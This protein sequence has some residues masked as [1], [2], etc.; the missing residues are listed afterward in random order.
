MVRERVTV[1]ETE[2]VDDEV[3]VTRPTPVSQTAR[4]IYYVMGVVNVLLL[5]RLIFQVFGA[6]TRSPFVSFIYGL[7]APLLAP[8]RGIFNVAAAGE[9]VID[10]AILVAMI[11]YALLAKGL[12]ELLYLLTR[13][14]VTSV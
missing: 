6:N 8:F 7:T 5:L 3:V 1:H 9:T 4:I 11:I 2:E 10:P 13:R 12:V 14:R